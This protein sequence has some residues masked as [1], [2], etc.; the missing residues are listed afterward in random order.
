VVDGCH[1]ARVIANIIVILTLAVLI[2]RPV[3]HPI[4][5]FKEVL[6]VLP[7]SRIRQAWQKAVHDTCHLHHPDK[8][9]QIEH[10]WA[11]D[12]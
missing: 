3:S 8:R 12:E 2:L 10:A 5:G 4:G 11:E 6:G 7:V 9:R 1:A